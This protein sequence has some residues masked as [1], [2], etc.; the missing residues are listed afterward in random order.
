[1]TGQSKR[2][3]QQQCRKFQF[4]LIRKRNRRRNMCLA[5]F[6][7]FLCFEVIRLRSTSSWAMQ[8]CSG[9]SV[10]FNKTWSDWSSSSVMAPFSG[11]SIS[12]LKMIMPYHLPAR[13]A[14]ITGAAT[15]FPSFIG[16]GIVVF[17]AGGKHHCRC[18][19]E[20]K[21]YFAD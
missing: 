17:I 14:L 1:M 3:L 9:D 21:G 4:L 19:E 8:N 2:L 12:R 5:S 15:A 6:S 18:H 10:C 20:Q 13:S 11:S 7:I 16:A